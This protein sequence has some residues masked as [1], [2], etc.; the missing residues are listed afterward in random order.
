MMKSVENLI[1]ERVIVRCNRAGVFYGTLSE[2]DGQEVALNDCRR[3][4]YWNGAA[5][6]HQLAA[7][8]V[9]AP[10]DCKFTMRVES[11]VLPDAIEI[12]PCTDKAIKCI[13]AVEEW[14]R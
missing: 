13:E 12:I 7:E 10:K 4:W 9:T 6:L 2:K 1:G 5:S 8:G 3:I 11:I 14:K